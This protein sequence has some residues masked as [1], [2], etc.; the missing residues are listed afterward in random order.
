MADKFF[1]KR[2]G[3]IN[4]SGVDTVDFIN[5]MS[6]ND[7]RKFNT[8]EFRKTILTTDKGRITDIINLL[9][10]EDRQ[11]ILTSEGFE[12]KVISHLEKYI[13]ID[14][15][16]LEKTED[17]YLH[18]IITGEN[19]FQ[20]MKK[21][22]NPESE[23]VKNKVYKSDKNDIIFYDDF[24]YESVNII[25]PE[26]NADKIKAMLHEHLEMSDS[27]YQN[28]RIEKGVAEGENELNERINPMECGFE[29]LISFNKGCYIGQEVIARL[30]AQEKRPKQM[31]KIISDREISNSEKIYDESGKETGFITS[32]VKYND[33]F[34]GLGFIRSQ[35]LDYEKVY[36]ISHENENYQINI[37]K[38]N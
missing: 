1:V 27:E 38:I 10:F 16:K 26:Q 17:I 4:C 8:G 14:D 20:I 37:S 15:V 31:V 32:S 24:K 6:T 9:N 22:I 21:F 5:R 25:C 13:I 19:C 12:E 7:L 11:I 29:K 18:F 36:F 28:F 30:D 35:F 34:N 2:A 33:K 23:T 3:V